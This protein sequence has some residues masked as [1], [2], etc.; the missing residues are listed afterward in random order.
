M[1][2]ILSKTFGSTEKRMN[3]DQDRY[4]ICQRNEMTSNGHDAK[5]IWKIKTLPISRRGS[6]QAGLFFDHIAAIITKKSNHC[7]IAELLSFFRHKI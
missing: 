7:A 6:A 5:N 1:K 2:N 4:S 3:Y